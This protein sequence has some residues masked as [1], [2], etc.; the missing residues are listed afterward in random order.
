MA[1]DVSTGGLMKFRYGK[2]DKPKIDEGLKKEIE[3][4]YG[5]Y[6]ERKAREEKRRKLLWRLA[7][8]AILVLIGFAVWRIFS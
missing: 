4:A 3:E 2:A 6:Y 5:K 8:L 1:E 7:G